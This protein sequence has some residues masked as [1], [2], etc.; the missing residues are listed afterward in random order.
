MT[1]FE[2]L[3]MPSL[4]GAAARALPVLWYSRELP[5]AGS[6]LSACGARVAVLVEP[7]WRATHTIPWAT[8]ANLRAMLALLLPRIVHH[9]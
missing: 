5:E 9:I 4:G 8:F 6:T 2:R 3:H 1:V 7:A